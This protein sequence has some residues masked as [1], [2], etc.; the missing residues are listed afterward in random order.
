MTHEPAETT[1]KPDNNNGPMTVKCPCGWTITGPATH[2]QKTV[3]HHR[4]EKTDPTWN[5]REQG[6]D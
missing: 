1:T 3:F 4:C 6:N 2:I 5:Q